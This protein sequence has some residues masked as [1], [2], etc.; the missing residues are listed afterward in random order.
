ML[1]R[2]LRTIKGCFKKI[3]WDIKEFISDKEKRYRLSFSPKGEDIE[4]IAYFHTAE[5]DRFFY[6]V[7]SE[8]TKNTPGSISGGSQNYSS[9]WE[10]LDKYHK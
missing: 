5:D 9:A 7:L 8:Y 1:K 2:I 6:K 10:Y 3:R 4:F